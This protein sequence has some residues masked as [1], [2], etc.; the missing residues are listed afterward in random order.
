MTA[1]K[2][3]QKLKQIQQKLP[4]MFS[5]FL[6]RDPLLPAYVYATQRKCG[7]PN[8]RCAK[9]QLHPGHSICFEEHGRRRCY[10]L[11]AHHRDQLGPWAENY[12]R[13]RQARRDLRRTVQQALDAIDEIEH[14]LRRSPSECV[15]KVKA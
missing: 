8:C 10:S 6:Q 2:A 11:T 4:H 15:A 5:P 1:S 9:G 7:N 12:R 13:F 14:A 3:R